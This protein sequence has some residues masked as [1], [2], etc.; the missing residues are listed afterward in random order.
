MDT[1]IAEDPVVDDL[2]TASAPKAGRW[3]FDPAVTAAFDDMLERSIPNYRDMRRITT[4]AAAW[5][6]DRI[7]YSGTRRPGVVDLGASRGTGLEPIID[8]FGARARFAA[9]ETSA[10]ML[11]VLRDRFEGLI[12]AGVV[13]VEDHDLRKGM[14]VLPWQPG[15]VLSVL[16]LQFLPIEYRQRLLGDVFRD[17]P[18]GGGMILVEK[19]LGSAHESNE[20]LADLY[21]GLKRGNGYTQEAI[22]R[23]ALSLEGVLVPVIELI[24]ERTGI[25]SIYRTGARPRLGRT[26]NPQVSWTVRT[27]RDCL[28]L[29]E[30]LDRF[31]LRAKKARDYMIWREAVRI[32]GPVTYCREQERLGNLMTQ[33]REGR[34][35][36]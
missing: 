18:S 31:P 10:P 9:V 3:E 7:G 2:K 24:R 6:L 27:K 19:V 28:A 4:D 21:H 32:W 29:T 14:P 17:L 11:E 33:L 34:R 35:Y 25:G 15:V 20:L 5:I 12:D 22:D 36:A 1:P 16:T 8:Q 30:R 23:K 26:G 13:R